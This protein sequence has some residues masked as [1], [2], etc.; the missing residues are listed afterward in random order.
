[1]DFDIFADKLRSRNNLAYGE[2][3]RVTVN[4]EEFLKLRGRILI[5]VILQKDS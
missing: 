2:F 1:M 4:R 5:P 3:I